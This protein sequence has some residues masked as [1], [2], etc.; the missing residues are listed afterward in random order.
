ML[1]EAEITANDHFTLAV[2]DY[3]V[4]RLKHSKLPILE[5]G[6]QFTHIYKNG[7]VKIWSVNINAA[8]KKLS[9]S[10]D[11]EIIPSLNE[12][13]NDTFKDFFA[14]TEYIT[15]CLIGTQ[16]IEDQITSV[17]KTSSDNNDQ[18][19][20]KGLIAKIVDAITGNEA[21][22]QKE[23]RAAFENFTGARESLQDVRGRLNQ[24]QEKVEKTRDCLSKV[25]K[26]Y[27]SKRVQAI[28]EKYAIPSSQAS[29]STTRV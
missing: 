25:K 28:R 9:V 14:G 1:S 3:V 8:S 5:D 4:E 16:L 12:V 22:A 20:G 6:L 29:S 26:Q 23:F 24:L 19:D 7:E 10:L 27:P 17:P 21:E 2:F 18:P 13:L 11:G 15:H